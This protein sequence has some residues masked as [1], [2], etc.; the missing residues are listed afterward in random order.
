MKDRAVSGT[1][2]FLMAYAVTSQDPTEREAAKKRLRELGLSA[3]EALNGAHRRLSAG[4]P[5][6]SLPN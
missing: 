2:L 6:D 5:P 3:Q 4:I 1:D